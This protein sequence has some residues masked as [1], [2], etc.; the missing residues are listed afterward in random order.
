[1]FMYKN[2]KHIDGGN[3]LGCIKKIYRW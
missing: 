3:H 2:W 1:M